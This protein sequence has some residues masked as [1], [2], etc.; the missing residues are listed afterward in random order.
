[1]LGSAHLRRPAAGRATSS[2]Y[3][4][5]GRGSPGGSPPGGSPRL[6][7]YLQYARPDTPEYLPHVVSN[8]LERLD[9]GRCGGARPATDGQRD[10]LQQA[11]QGHGPTSPPPDQLRYLLGERATRAARVSTAE[12]TNL[13]MDLDGTAANR[14]VGNSPAI[15]TVHTPGA[16][17]TSRTMC[18]PSRASHLDVHSLGGDQ[19]PLHEQAR[20]VRE[21]TRPTQ[22]RHLLALTASR[23]PAPE[24][25]TGSAPTATGFLHYCRARAVPPIDIQQVS[26]NEL[27]Q[28]LQGNFGRPNGRGQ[29][30]R[31]QRCWRRGRALPRRAASHLPEMTADRYI[32]SGHR[33]LGYGYDR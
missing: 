30:Q 22:T 2:R 16:A 19:N 21:Q 33:A 8:V 28:S 18:R 32:D 20:E 10:I 7:D 13:E 17:A 31:E 26:F 1:M 23:G 5:G 4:R 15:A 14:L 11:Q 12:P 9:L 3:A 27:L 24:W 25:F 6:A 29:R